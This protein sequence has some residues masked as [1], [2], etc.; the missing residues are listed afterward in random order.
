[1]I[2]PYQGNYLY[3]SLGIA[4]A[5]PGTQGVYYCGCP[6]LNG[7]I[8]Y[9]VGR[10]E[11]IRARL[12]DHLRD[13]YWPS[14]THFGFRTCST[15]TETLTLEASEISRLQPQYNIIGKTNF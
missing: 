14:V 2:G 12:Q 6:S 7:L 1:M 10:S 15:W 3:N 11:N 5:A 8:A 9:Y 4:I 13:D